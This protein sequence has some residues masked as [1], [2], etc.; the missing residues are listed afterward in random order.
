MPTCPLATSPRTPPCISLTCS[1]PGT[2]SN[3]TTSSGCL[4]Q[5]NL[6]LEVCTYAPARYCQIAHPMLLI[7]RSELLFK[8]ERAVELR[9]MFLKGTTILRLVMYGML[10]MCALAKYSC[11]CPSCSVLGYA[12]KY[13]DEYAPFT[14]R[15]TP[16]GT[17]LFE[18]PGCPN[19]LS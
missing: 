10:C 2:C 8:E 5:T 11:S 18:C 9:S 13:H 19:D 7:K 14:T 4:P 3:T 16:N 1:T 12:A 6:T 17:W 15:H